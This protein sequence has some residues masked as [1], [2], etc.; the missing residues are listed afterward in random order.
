MRV[1][2]RRCGGA[3]GRFGRGGCGFHPVA[4]RRRSRHPVAGRRRGRA[5]ASWAT[6]CTRWNWW[7][8]TCSTPQASRGLAS[9]ARPACSLL[10][11]GNYLT[12]YQMALIEAGNLD[13]LVL[14]PSRYRPPPG[15]PRGCAF[16]VFDPRRNGEALLRWLA[17]GRRCQ[18]AVHPWTYPL[19]KLLT[20]APRPRGMPHIAATY[21]VVELAGRPAVL[22]EWLIGVA[23]ADWPG[24]GASAS[25]GRLVP[26]AFAGGVGSCAPLMRPELVHGTLEPSS[27][28]CTPE[29]VVKL[30]GLGQPRWLAASPLPEGVE[31]NAAGDLR[32]LGR[33]AEGRATADRVTC[34]AG[35]KRCPTDF[36][37]S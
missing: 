8:P 33:I 17:E 15:Q 29:G 23:G 30:C 27:L 7:T 26:S 36:R 12:L 28:V 18:D 1:V 6:C 37:P 5:T 2:G 11:A 14:G 21:E 24:A 3:R 34:G 25:F 32:A 16:R 10:L 9:T 4:G 19:S 13:S 31:A 20:A 35:A 22:Q